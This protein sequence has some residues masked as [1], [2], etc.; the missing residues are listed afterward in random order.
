MEQLSKSEKH[1]CKKTH[2]KRKNRK[3]FTKEIKNNISEICS[4]ESDMDFLLMDEECEKDEKH[5]RWIYYYKGYRPGQFPEK[6]THD[7]V[8]D[9]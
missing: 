1:I 9:L 7:C 2:N 8:K 5:P 4:F 6:K 3:N